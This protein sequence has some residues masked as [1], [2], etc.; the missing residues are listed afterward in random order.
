MQ[1]SYRIDGTTVAADIEGTPVQGT[2][3]VIAQDYGDPLQNAPWY[4]K[5]YTV[6]PL[7]SDQQMALMRGKLSAFICDILADHGVD[8]K[9]FKLERYHDFADEELHKAV[10]P[11]TRR[12]TH[13]QIGLDFDQLLVRLSEMAGAELSTYNPLMK[14]DHWVICRINRPRSPDFNPVHKDIYEAVDLVDIPLRMVNF[15]IPLCGVG[16]ATGLPVAAGSHLLRED[17][18]QRVKS[19]CVM[20]GVP[21]NVSAVTSWDG[22]SSLTSVIP[23]P[24]DVMCFSSHMVH[25]LARN[26]N[27]DTT[28]ISLEFRLFAS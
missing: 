1:I 2:D 25:G 24:G 3:R 28:R 5:G 9:E 7:F 26:L 15:W 21:F 13:D 22:D 27:P 19:G 16:G 17:Q 20:N 23:K 6:A 12:L 4:E 14:Q 11:K 8:T 18:I 10:F